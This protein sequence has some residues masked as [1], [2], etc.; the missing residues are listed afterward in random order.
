MKV[1][2]LR[3]LLAAAVFAA[4]VSAATAKDGVLPAAAKPADPAAVADLYREKTWNWSHGAA[5]F[6][7]NQRFTAWSKKGEAASYAEGRWFVTA[8]GKACFQAVWHAK[9][10][11]GDNLTC[12]DHRTSNGTI[13]QRK[14]PTG[15]W[16]VFKSAR[17]TK[18]DEY[19]KFKS[20]DLVSRRTP[21]VLS[22]LHLQED[23]GNGSNPDDSAKEMEQ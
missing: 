13:Y 18:T 3:Q 1:S 17:S 9:T 4:T 12:F 15:T 7:P 16:Y 11:S 20:G 10:G 6:A 23:L 2:F 21:Q 22:E 14:A 19:N 5:F 8:R